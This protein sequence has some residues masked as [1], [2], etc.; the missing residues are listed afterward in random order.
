MLTTGIIF[1]EGIM[2]AGK[3]TTA[4]FI[5]DQ[6]RQNQIAAHF[7]DE[8]S[9]LRMGT[10][11]PHFHQPWLD[12][13][14]AEYIER[15][16]TKW[17][18]FV[19]EAQASHTT[20]VFD[21]QLF[22][23]NM[24]DLLLMNAETGALHRYVEQV[25]EILHVISPVV[26]FLYQAD[27]A[28]ALRAVCDARGSDFKAY[29]VNWKVNSPYCVHRSLHGYDGFVQ[30]YR[31]YRAICDD[32]FGKLT[33]PKL[34]I[35]TTEGDWPG[36]Y[37]DIL[38]FLQLPF[39]IT[40]EDLAL[41]DKFTDRARA[42][43]RIALEE[44]KRLNYEYVGT[45][46]ILLAIVK[47]GNGLA[48]DAMKKM[49]VDLKQLQM[50]IEETLEAKEGVAVRGEIPFSPRAKKVLELAVREAKHFGHNYLGTEHI[51]L[52]LINE[53][54]GRAAQLLAQSEVTLEKARSQ[55]VKLLGGSGTKNTI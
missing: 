25:I 45:E 29:Q 37:R 34:A 13:T 32:I 15:S 53:G 20:S 18:N 21:G 10:H 1:V 3:S 5:T 19:V 51:L 55:V 2:G 41:Y 4:K 28:Q 52:G 6:L 30:L 24:T 46:H 54:E 14:V 40:K 35:D 26:I 17:Q 36:Y 22:H 48:A 12:V 9:P 33:I 43:I 31:V 47:E 50:R 11:L 44:S 39:K 16:L 8:G 27:V 23:G 49:G 42:V 38:T 7:F